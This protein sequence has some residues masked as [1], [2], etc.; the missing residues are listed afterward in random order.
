[1]PPVE[2]ETEAYIT[3]HCFAENRMKTSEGACVL[4]YV[5]VCV[6]VCEQIAKGG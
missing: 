5:C 2:E 6:C 3:R 4:I 1:M